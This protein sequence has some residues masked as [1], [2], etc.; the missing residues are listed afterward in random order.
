MKS[1]HV[2]KWENAETPAT[3]AKIKVAGYESTK[4][5]E[6]NDKLLRDRE[7]FG[8]MKRSEYAS[9]GTAVKERKGRA[10]V[11]GKSS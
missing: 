5:W 6:V 7:V 2:G 3:Q 4:C 9:S 10:G 8:D 11:S 1:V